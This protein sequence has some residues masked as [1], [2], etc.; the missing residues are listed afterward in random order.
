MHIAK[1]YTELKTKNKT[2]QNNKQTNKQTNKKQLHDRSWRALNE[3]FHM[4]A[5]KC[6]NCAWKCKLFLPIIFGS[7]KVYRIY[8]KLDPGVCFCR[9]CLH[10]G[11]KCSRDSTLM[12][13]HIL[14]YTSL[15]T[16]VTN[17][18]QNTSILCLFLKAPPLVP[19][20]SPKKYSDI[21]ATFS[22]WNLTKDL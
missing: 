9:N 18:P 13:S 20:F 8:W 3:N 6:T 16:R 19:V 5:V 2:K 7:L 17:M 10:Y 22:S 11:S 15:E 12:D 1:E 4:C 14:S 21:H